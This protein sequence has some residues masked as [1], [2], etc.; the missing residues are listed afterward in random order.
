MGVISVPKLSVEEYL[1]IDRAAELKSEYHDGEMFP[2]VAV[3]MAHSVISANVTYSLVGRLKG[4]S[5]FVLTSPMRVRVSPTRFVYPD[6]AVICG[7]PVL[8]DEAQDTLTN[9]KV[10]IEVLSPSTADYDYGAK[11]ALYRRMPSFEE[12][13]LIAQGDPRI[14]VFHKAH[15]GGWV[16]HTY[17]GL[18]TTIKL[19]SLNITLALADIYAGIDL[20]PR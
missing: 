11:F 18:E 8:T 5:C 17:E 16:L 2:I 6:L 1:K 10:I 9:P 13:I 7:T 14:E 3:S 19:K 20:N 12:Y 4:G 15:D